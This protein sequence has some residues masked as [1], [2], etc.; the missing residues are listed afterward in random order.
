MSSKRPTVLPS[1]RPSIQGTILTDVWSTA[2]APLLDLDG[3]TTAAAGYSVRKLRAAYSGKPMKVRRA[4]DSDEADVA[5]DDSGKVSSASAITVTSGDYSGTMTLG[6]FLSGT[7]GHVTTLYDQVGSENATNTTAAKQPY[8]RTAGSTT[9][10]DTVELL[11]DTAG[12]GGTNQYLASGF[13]HSNSDDS[14][15]Q[16]V[17]TQVNSSVHATDHYG[18]IGNRYY[19]AYGTE[20]YYRNGY[21]TWSIGNAGDNSYQELV[22]SNGARAGQKDIVIA[23]FEPSLSSNEQKIRVNQTLTQTDCTKDVNDYGYGPLQIGRRWAYQSDAASDRTYYGNVYEVILWA[24][25][26]SA[27][28]AAAAETNTMAYYSIASL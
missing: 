23:S 5:F 27:T 3:M 17:V 10:G 1:C 11:Y 15:T 8:L 9:I 14:R 24:S 25:A 7:T 21:Y 16:L 20:I 22:S 2:V 28:N 4:S 12:S 6:A 19:Q 26:L 18:L 13:D